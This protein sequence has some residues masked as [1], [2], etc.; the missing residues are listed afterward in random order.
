MDS[1][2]DEGFR[3]YLNE[4]GYSPKTIE[5]ICYYNRRISRNNI[6]E[7]VLKSRYYEFSGQTRGNIRWVLNLCKEYQEKIK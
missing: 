6:N 5:H 1:F 3:T 7:D 2:Y 4:K